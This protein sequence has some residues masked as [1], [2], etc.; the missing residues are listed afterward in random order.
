MTKF[1]RNIPD[2]A[3]ELTSTIVGSSNFGERSY[4]R[5]LEA[6]MLILTTNSTLKARIRQEYHKLYNFVS[7]M[8]L[9]RQLSVFVYIVERFFR[10]FF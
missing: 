1:L 5:D 8:D 9:G 7:P 3:K 10:S 6:Q 2:N 4:N